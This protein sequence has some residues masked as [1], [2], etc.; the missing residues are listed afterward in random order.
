MVL[1][2]PMR[3]RQTPLFSVVSRSYSV[4]PF[5]AQ[6]SVR[7]ALRDFKGDAL[8]LVVNQ[9][10]RSQNHWATQAVRL[11]GEIADLSTCFL[12]QKHP[13][14]HVPSVETKF[15]EGFEAAGG[16]AGEI[17][18]GGTVAADPVR[19]EREIPIVV[20]VGAGHAL[21]RGKSGAKQ[22]GRE[23]FN[24]GDTD[25][26]AVEGGA[27][28]ASRRKKFISNGVVHYAGQNR[29]AL[30]QRDRDAEA[31]IAVREIRRAI[32]WIDVPAKLRRIVVP[33]TFFRGDRMIREIFRQPFHDRPLGALVGLGNQVGVALVSDVRRPGE[34]LA[35]YLPSFLSDFDGGFQ[36]VFGHNE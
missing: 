16:H 22:A 4:D 3:Q 12:D 1:R 33:G 19:A 24:L 7:V 31:G 14:G 10:V 36:I 18:S 26:P 11:S 13:R 6:G 21:V 20:N 17:E 32:Q 29:I 28:A 25:R 5:A 27:F 8:R 2:W 9:A 30:R 35:K 15:P 34:F 23:R